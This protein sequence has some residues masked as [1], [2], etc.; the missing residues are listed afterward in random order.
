MSSRKSDVF[1]SLLALSFP[2]PYPPPPHPASN[3][4]YTLHLS[5]PVS[6]WNCSFVSC[7]V[8]LDSLVVWEV[9]NDFCVSIEG[10][11]GNMLLPWTQRPRVRGCERQRASRRCHPI[12]NTTERGCTSQTE[13]TKITLSGTTNIRAIMLAP[14]TFSMS[15]YTACRK[16]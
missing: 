9:L 16:W 13:N 15:A 1:V 10:S 3:R 12:L 11:G 6:F 5:L 4:S 7:S 14:P 2:P 8:L